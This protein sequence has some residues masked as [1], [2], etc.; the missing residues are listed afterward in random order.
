[1]K[2]LTRT[3][4]A[5][6]IALACAACR[7][8]AFAQFYTIVPIA[9][10]GANYVAGE[11]INDSGV[12]AGGFFDSVDL[13]GGFRLA[14]SSV[15]LMPA[16]AVGKGVYGA[17]INNAGVVA[18]Y[19][20]TANDERRA[21]VW[22]GSTLIDLGTLGGDRSNAFGIN[23]VG[24]VVGAS[25]NASAT[26]RPFSWSVSTGIVEL[27]ISLGGASASARAIN[28]AGLIAGTARNVGGD[29]HAV[30]FDPSTSTTVDLGTLGG[31]S[32]FSNGI[33]PNGYVVGLS[34][35]PND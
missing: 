19:A 12:V 7:S 17:S 23:S 1:M 9:V 14:G 10:P 16:L 13:D 26:D 15:E 21:V 34:D 25:R 31:P 24:V 30:L 8:T 18:G 3:L 2:R 22:D 11:E 4:F 35:A 32:S 5:L 20:F 29:D 33:S 28:D 6:G 27:P